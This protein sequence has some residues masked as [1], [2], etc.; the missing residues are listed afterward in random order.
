[1]PSARF[2]EIASLVR[3]W[4][5]WGAN[6][7]LGTLNLID[8][9]AR[10]RGVSSVATGETLSLGLALGKA[11]GIQPGFIE[12]RV[13]PD[14]TMIAING[15]L[16]PDPEWICSSEDVVTMALQAATHWDGL[17][18]VSYDGKLYNGYP[19]DSI[20]SLGASSLGIEQVT[21]LLSRGV[22]LD[23]PRALGLDR[24]QPGYAITP[25]DLDLACQMA[26]VS[27][28]SGDIVLVRTGQ[29]GFLTLDPDKTY[30]APLPTKDLIAYTFP[31]AGLTIETALWFHEHDVAAVGTD[32]LV[33]EVFPGER[34][35][36]YLP[37]HLL[38][39]V[40]MG[41]TQGQNFVLDRL[42]AACG[43]DGRYTFLLDASPLPF[44]G[45][46][47]SPLNPIALR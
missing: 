43:E 35:E 27:V 9:E 29:Q 40:E 25:S 8:A 26:K 44:T 23:V 34:E 37:V 14:R 36:D 21:S 24:L 47:G 13:D 4:G 33:G 16:S 32:T 19:A 5:R 20:T 46:V 18:H 45:G 28:L 17:A 42:A 3:N 6:D 15:P 39:L 11:E 10:L 31:S 22:L 38:H 2:H 7:Q 41:M 1:M 12:G 30:N